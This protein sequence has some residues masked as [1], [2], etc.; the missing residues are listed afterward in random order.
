V[1]EPYNGGE[2]V[3]VEVDDGVGEVLNIAV[4][5]VAATAIAWGR[6]GAQ[7]GVQLQQ[8][9]ADGAHGAARAALRLGAEDDRALL[10]PHRLADVVQN[11]SSFSSGCNFHGFN[12]L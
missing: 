8:G 1:R 11:R 6:Q 9:G 7:D 2:R 3:E 4:T 10:A 5:H 12:S